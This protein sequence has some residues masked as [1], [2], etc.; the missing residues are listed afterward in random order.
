MSENTGI[1]Y[2]VA[3][4]IGNLA[5]ISRRAIDVLQTVDLIAAE[6]TRHSRKLLTHYG[7]NQ[8]MMALHEHNERERAGKI[9]DSLKSGK[10]VALISDAGTPLISDP[11]YHLTRMVHEAGIRIVPIPGPSAMI[12]ALSVAGLATDRFVFEGFLPAK[13][14]GR[15]NRLA[16]LTNETRTL[17]F[18]EAPHRLLGTVTAICKHF[19]PERMVVLARELTKMFETIR[20]SSLKDMLSWIS[21]NP[22][23]QKG[24]SVL[25][26]QGAEEAG[27]SGM[28][29][30]EVDIE[31]LLM[32]LLEVMSVKDAA[33]KTA[34]LTDRSKNELYQR[35]LDIKKQSH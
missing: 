9:I 28:T 22:E 14:V 4:P 26:V 23:Q 2:I 27:Q 8:P 7:I 17:V 12:A 3:T 10:S 31:K 6:D 25:I 15:D 29:T 1:L 20:Q 16:E 30:A 21:E 5:D 19:G 11:G 13:A 18:Y 32:S 24:E 33:H 34:E 35:A